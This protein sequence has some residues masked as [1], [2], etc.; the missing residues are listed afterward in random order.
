M[1]DHNVDIILFCFVLLNIDIFSVIETYI[2]EVYSIGMK[3]ARVTAEEQPSPESYDNL[4]HQCIVCLDEI[5]KKGQN[6]I[7]S[8]L[9]KNTHI[10]D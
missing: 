4:Y 1:G 7:Y 3:S 6:F 2:T 5:N 8:G 10:V 9:T